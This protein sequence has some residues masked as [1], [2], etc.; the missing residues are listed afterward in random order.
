MLYLYRKETC[1]GRQDR[2]L[3]TKLF[4]L[5]GWLLLSQTLFAQPKDLNLYD[6]DSK[7]YYFG[8]TLGV[9]LARFQTEL[10]PRFLQYD[11]VYVA[12][13]INSGGF[14]LGLSATGHLTNRFETRFHPQLEFIE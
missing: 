2:T 11:S 10:H 5:F 8:I 13:P 6:H 1:R 4:L 14:T 7:P 3:V 9:N 12:E